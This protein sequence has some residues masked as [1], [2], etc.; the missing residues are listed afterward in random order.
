MFEHGQHPTGGS[1][2]LRYDPTEG[3]GLLHF[4]NMDMPLTHGSLRAEPVTYFHDLLKVAATQKCFI[5][6]SLLEMSLS[7]Q[8]L[9]TRFTG[10]ATSVSSMGGSVSSKTLRAKVRGE[11]FSNVIT[12]L[13]SSK[14]E[15]LRHHKEAWA[16]WRI[17][18][19]IDFDSPSELANAVRSL[20]GSSY[21]TEATLPLR[22][23]KTRLFIAENGHQRDALT[24]EEFK[25][26][27]E[28]EYLNQLDIKD[29]SVP[30]IRRVTDLNE[31][32]FGFAAK[33]QLAILL[34]RVNPQMTFH[35]LESL[36]LPPNDLFVAVRIPRSSELPPVICGC[37]V[38]EKDAEISGITEFT[39]WVVVGSERPEYR[40][41]SR[42]V[43]VNLLRE[44]VHYHSQNHPELVLYGEFNKVRAEAAAKN[45]GFC[46]SRGSMNLHVPIDGFL[47]NFEVLQY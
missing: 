12:S 32:P 37:V 2:Q 35:Q 15:F 30:Q 6:S 28:P 17:Q 41:W 19:I 39:D 18:G 13:E 33:L 8:L 1:F 27:I 21:I 34:A 26:L 20:S 38:L 14:A 24:F 46:I 42:G 36:T 31:A 23:G 5:P 45:N 4:V 44:A 10:A 16:S 3:P 25:G 11:D 29:Y 47:A 43:G 22:N 9:A 40:A 7:A